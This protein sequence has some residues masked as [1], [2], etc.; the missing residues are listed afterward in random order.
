MR[1]D[2]IRNVT[3][4]RCSD[5]SGERFRVGGVERAARL[6]RQQEVSI[7]DDSSRDR[8]ALSLGTAIPHCAI[9][10]A[11]PSTE[12]AVCGTFGGVAFQPSEG[13]R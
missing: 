1:H 8:D 6:V 11:A 4:T 2:D 9:A 7:S 3:L 10:V 13:W 12:S 5:Q